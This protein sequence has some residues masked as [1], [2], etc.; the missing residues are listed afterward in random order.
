MHVITKKRLREFGARHPA[1]VTPLDD[2]YRIMEGSRFE[3][4][5]EVKEVFGQADFI[6]GSLAVFNIG[7]NKFRIVAEVVFRYQ[8]VLVREVFTHKEYD[9][10][11]KARRKGR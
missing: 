10:W 2:W 4:P 3:Q 8:I 1:A 5:S 11:S 7:G 6:E 9:A